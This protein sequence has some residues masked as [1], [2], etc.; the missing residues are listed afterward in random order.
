LKEL[1]H[2]KVAIAKSLKIEFKLKKK[3]KLYFK[4]FLVK[5]N[6][7]VLKST[8]KLL[9]KSALKC[10]FQSSLC[11]KQI[12]PVLKIIT[13]TRVILKIVISLIQKGMKKEMMMLLER[14]LALKL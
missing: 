8:S 11:F 3:F 7:Y 4:L 12:F 2:K 14:L 9:N 13:N 1:S 5:K 10:S 6:A